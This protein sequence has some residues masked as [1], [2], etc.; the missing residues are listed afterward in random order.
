MESTPSWT[1]FQKVGTSPAPGNTVPIPDDGRPERIVAFQTERGR[2]HYLGRA[3]GDAG[4]LRQQGGDALVGVD[5]G[6]APRAYLASRD[7]DTMPPPAADHGP[8]STLTT[9]V[10]AR[11]W[12]HTRARVSRASLV[13]E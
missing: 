8:Q 11:R 13:A 7:A 12:R 5:G 4:H 3:V 9:R 1:L 10:P 2:V 6:E